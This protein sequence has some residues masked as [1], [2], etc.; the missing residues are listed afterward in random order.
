MESLG[1]ELLRVLKT[2]AQRPEDIRDDIIIINLRAIAQRQT[3]ENLSEIIKLIDQAILCKF[4]TLTR[5]ELQAMFDLADLKET[6]VYKDAYSEGKLE[7]KQEGKIEVIP[8]LLSAGLSP[9]QIAQS[10]QLDLSLVK[11]I[12]NSKTQ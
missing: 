9:E 11:H 5:E 7:G 4:P 6:R 8:A 2:K 3:L 1:I 12:A 10:L